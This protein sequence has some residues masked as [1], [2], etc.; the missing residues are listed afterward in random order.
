MVWFPGR[1]FD[2]IVEGYPTIKPDSLEFLVRIVIP[3]VSLALLLIYLFRDKER[4]LNNH[5]SGK[6]IIAGRGIFKPALFLSIGLILGILLVYFLLKP[7]VLP[8]QATLEESKRL[9]LQ[10]NEFRD[11]CKREGYRTEVEALAN[12]L[13]EKRAREVAILYNADDAYSSEIYKLFSQKLKD[14]K[15][16]IIFSD[17][18]KLG[19]KSF[20]SRLKI[21]ESLKPEA[22]IFLG[23]YEERMAFLEDISYRSELAFWKN[24]LDKIKWIE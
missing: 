14:E 6:T 5:F 17:M 10:H 11:F 24:R 23:M 3:I 9:Q 12:W 2:Y 21:I 18:F 1:W 22:V 4:A 16:K 20:S 7:Q 19:E 13:R 8:E 15:V